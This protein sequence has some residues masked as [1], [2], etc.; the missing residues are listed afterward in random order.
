ML[1]S[2]KYTINYQQP[3]TFINTM[4]S[5]RDAANLSVCFR[6]FFIPLDDLQMVPT[7][8]H[9]SIT[10]IL[11]NIATGTPKKYSPL[12]PSLGQHIPSS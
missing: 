12:F 2:F 9:N 10:F 8:M 6:D 4:N 7:V 1:S 3:V 5:R 11:N